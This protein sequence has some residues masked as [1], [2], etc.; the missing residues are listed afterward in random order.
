MSNLIPINYDNDRQTVSARALHEFLEVDTQYSIWFERMTAYGFSRDID[1][2]AINQKR[3]TGQG[4]ETTYTDH[5]ITIEMAKELC[6]IQRTEKGKMAREYFIGIERQWNSPEAIMARALKMAD[7]KIISLESNI[8]S[9]KDELEHQKPLVLFAETCIASNDSLLVREVAK[10][11]S[12][13]GIV[14]GE[15][16]LWQKLREWEVV[17]GSN[18]PYQKAFDAGWF[19][20][21]QGTYNTPYG[22]ETYRTYKVTPKGQIYIIEKLKKSA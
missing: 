15:K 11:A 20:T 8:T 1:F 10:L 13:Q 3:L 17:N 22:S 12:K 7:R 19:E 21:R 9:L 16:R 5:Q 18:E 2:Q 14:I 6:M 4:N